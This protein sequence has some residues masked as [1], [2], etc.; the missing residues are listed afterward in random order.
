MKNPILILITVLASLS[1]TLREASADPTLPAA[2]ARQLS[3]NP[4]TGAMTWPL[5][6]D[7]RAANGFGSMSTQNA[8]AVAI[9]G[10]TINGVSITGVTASAAWATITGK[11]TTITGYG[12]TD[13]QPLDSDLTGIAALSTTAYGRSFLPLADAA[14]ARTLLGLGSVAT[15][16][17]SSYDLSGAA[18]T[19]QAFAIQRGNHTGTQP[20]GTITGAPTTLPG[21]GI[22]DAQPL[23]SDLTGIAALSTTAYGRS[24]LPLADAA[25]A[26][27]LLGLGNMSLQN[28]AALDLGR[29]SSDGAPDLPVVSI[30]DNSTTPMASPL[31]KIK[32]F[33]PTTPP[34]LLRAVNFDNNTIF[35]ISG[36][37][38]VSLFKYGEFTSHYLVGFDFEGEE[39]FSITGAGVFTGKG[40]GLTSLNASNISTGTTAAARLGSGSGGAT[41]FLRED[42]TW[43]PIAGGGGAT[44]G[45]EVATTSGTSVN[46]TIPAGAKHITLMLIG[47][48]TSGVSPLLVQLG[49][50]GGIETTGYIGGVTAAAGSVATTSSPAGYVLTGATLAGSTYTGSITVTLEKESTQMWASRHGLYRSGTDGTSSGA[51]SKATSATTT[52][53]RLTTA[54]GG[55]TFDAGAASIS[56]SP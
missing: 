17:A 31:I 13:A 43:Q 22:T 8:N 35:G 50:S 23:D 19:A 10:G 34:D 47:V 44:L 3:A 33:N 41:K 39:L 29:I 1:L 55:D 20:W 21:Y 45:T 48:S 7:F 42:S 26:R 52:T 37:S 9:T 49:D 56:S 32:Q 2:A 40:S 18:A 14:A 15:T 30:F 6:G 51:G 36:N 27:T 16:P 38:T 25:A 5:P 4:A 46:F 12:I 28:G 11:P 24:F 54:G 53:I